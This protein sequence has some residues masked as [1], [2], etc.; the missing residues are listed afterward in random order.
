GHRAGGRSIRPYN[1]HMSVSPA[2]LPQ[3][4]LKPKRAAPFFGRHPWVYPGAI[5]RVEGDP[6]DGGAVDLV[7]S[8]GNFIARGLYNGVSKIR[9]RLLTWDADTPLDEAF[10]RKKIEAAVRLRRDVLGFDSTCRLVFSE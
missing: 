10:F 4:I 6:V 9:V 5:D 3:V 1:H 8:A 7:S 2:M